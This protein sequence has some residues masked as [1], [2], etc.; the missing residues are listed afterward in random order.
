MAKGEHE[1]GKHSGKG[2]GEGR[3]S[4]NV[5]YPSTGPQTGTGRRAV[6]RKPHKAE[7]K[8][9]D[10]KGNIINKITKALWG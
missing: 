3:R 10:G 6:G 7:I 9:R 2:V 1:P 8:Q 4:M 5:P